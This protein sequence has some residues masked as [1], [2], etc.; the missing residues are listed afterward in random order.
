MG[1]ARNPK[2]PISPSN[3]RYGKDSLSDGGTIVKPSTE[4][5]SIAKLR[6]RVGLTQHAL[7][8]ATGIPVNRIVFFETSRIA[9]DPGEL[10]KI[11]SALRKRA[12]QTA[13]DAMVGA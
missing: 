2:F 5:R 11:R 9:L 3:L 13:A 1:L 7:S 10:D 6:R 12:R 8:A 4:N